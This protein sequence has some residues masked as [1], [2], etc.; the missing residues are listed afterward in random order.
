MRI[1]TLLSTLLAATFVQADS[2]PARSTASRS[3]P[4][5][6]PRIAIPDD[7]PS[8]FWTLECPGKAESQ[9][10][11]PLAIYSACHFEGWQMFLKEFGVEGKRVEDCV[12]KQ[13]MVTLAGELF[14]TRGWEDGH[15]AC[16]KEIVRLLQQHPEPR[17]RW[18][19][20]NAYCPRPTPPPPPA[21]PAKQVAARQAPPVGG[22]V[23]EGGVS[24]TMAPS[25]DYLLRLE[26]VSYTEPADGHEA[27]QTQ[28]VLHS[29]EAV[30]RVGQR[31]HGKTTIGDETI[32]FRG[33][34]KTWKG[35]FSVQAEYLHTWPSNIPNAKVNSPNT[36]S[37]MGGTT[38]KLGKP[39]MLATLGS[40]STV[41]GVEKAVMWRLQVTVTKYVPEPM[42]P[43]RAK[44][45]ALPAQPLRGTVGP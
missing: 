4:L 22:V 25:Q 26:K 16:R 35:D 45:D 9:L 23:A 29:V 41:D 43:R 38:V 11:F 42:E 2:P 15:A 7:I 32:I 10:V 33:E 1:A 5:Y 37:A 36:T 34:L 14:T 30:A 18:W 13:P 40:V 12:Y 21:Q 44:A 19:A 3:V 27:P 24:T 39:G 6:P 28:T 20:K 17:V 8:T 31:F